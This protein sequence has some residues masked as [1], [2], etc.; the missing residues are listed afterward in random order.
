[1]SKKKENAINKED[2]LELAKQNEFLKLNLKIMNGLE[3]LEKEGELEPDYNKLADQIALKEKKQSVVEYK[4]ES[5]EFYFS[6]ITN[7]YDCFGEDYIYKLIMEYPEYTALILHLFIG[8]AEE[9]TKYI[10]TLENKIKE[11]EK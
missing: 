11:L 10:Q 7:G 2:I 1:M 8:Y 6:L 4:P 5:M 9:N 3:L